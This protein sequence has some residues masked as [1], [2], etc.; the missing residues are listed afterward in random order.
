MPTQSK[1]IEA[2]WSVPLAMT[3]PTLSVS[4]TGIPAS[5]PALAAAVAPA[6]VDENMLMPSTSSFTAFA[7]FWSSVSAS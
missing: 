2:T 7:M 4:T 1:S 3:V 6:S 5:L